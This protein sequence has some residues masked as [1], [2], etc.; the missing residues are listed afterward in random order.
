MECSH[1]VRMTNIFTT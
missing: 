1:N